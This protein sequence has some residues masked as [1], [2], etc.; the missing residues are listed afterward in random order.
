MSEPLAQRLIDIAIESPELHSDGEFFS[1][2]SPREIGPVLEFFTL[3]H[4]DKNIVLDS[5]AKHSDYGASL[6]GFLYRELQR[7]QYGRA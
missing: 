4:D 6:G 5:L 1:R 3:S 2:G 7:D